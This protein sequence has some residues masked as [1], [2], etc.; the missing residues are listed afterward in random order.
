MGLPT[1]EP[2][3]LLLLGSDL[4]NGLLESLLEIGRITSNYKN[5]RDLIAIDSKTQRGSHDQTSGKAAL[6]L[7]SAWANENRLVLV[8]VAVDNKSNEITAIPLL[9]DLRDLRGVDLTIGAWYN[10]GA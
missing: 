9:L 4:T 1:Q 10:P 7:V 3:S 5:P 6:Q 2:G 8:Q